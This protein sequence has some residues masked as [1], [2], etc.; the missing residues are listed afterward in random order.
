[1]RSI[2]I[3][4]SMMIAVLMAIFLAIGCAA[5]KKITQDI[6]GEGKALKKKIAFLPIVNE[7][8]YGG[9]DF[10]ASA[11]IHLNTFLKRFCDGLYI[12]DSQKTR[13]LLKEVPRL[14]SG[15]LDN[16][17]LA[18]LG[19]SLGLN[20]VLEESLSGIKCLAEKRGIW[21]FRDTCMLAQLCVCVRAY[22]IETGA[23]LF[24]EVVQGEVEVSEDDWHNLK[25]RSGY[26]KEIADRLLAKTTDGICKRICELLG[27]EPWEGYITSCSENTFTLSAGKDVGLAIGDVL[28]VFGT[29][30]PI[31]GSA[32]QIYLVPGPKIGEIRITKVHRDRA[33]AIRILGSDL[34]KSSHVKLK[35]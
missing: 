13:N 2:R 17:A 14:P 8:G 3:K 29:S 20:V 26:R 21:G 22:D 5:T 16:L 12:V 7:A 31:K 4:G 10:Q 18:K 27:D 35:P 32:G 15:Q 24:D 34:Q 25:K 1:M 11:R 33:E 28:E 19:R 23:I 6:L 30:E 9:K